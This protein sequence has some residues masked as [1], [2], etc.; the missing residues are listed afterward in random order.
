[1]DIQKI[2]A[3][4]REQRDQVSAVIEALEKISDTQTP[5]RGR[6]PKW[7]TLNRIQ[8]SKNG[9]NGSMNRS[10]HLPAPKKSGGNS[11]FAATNRGPGN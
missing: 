1:M 7:L 9:V 11:T 3:G 8:A 4:L 2:L 6:P 5:R 10:P